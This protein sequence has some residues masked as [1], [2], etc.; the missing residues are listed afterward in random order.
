MHKAI[1]V[2]RGITLTYDVYFHQHHE[3]FRTK[4]PKKSKDTE[5]APIAPIIQQHQERKILLEPGAKLTPKVVLPTASCYQPQLKSL[6]SKPG[7]NS[8]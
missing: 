6:A 8:L 4:E 3:P 5:T 1:L 7:W 2:W